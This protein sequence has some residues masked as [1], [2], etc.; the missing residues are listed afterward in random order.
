MEPD[1]ERHRISTRSDIRITIEQPGRVRRGHVR[2][3]SAASACHVA[4]PASPL[5]RHQNRPDVGAAQPARAHARR[6]PLHDSRPPP[7]D[8]ASVFHQRDLKRGIKWPWRV[9]ARSYNRAA[10][11]TFFATPM[12]SR[13]S[14]P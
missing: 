13:G 5:N 8:R 2:A 14:A 9:A 3:V 1:S 11:L 6:T 7:S 12:P 4:P 10:S